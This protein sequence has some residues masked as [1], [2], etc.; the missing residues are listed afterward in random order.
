MKVFSSLTLLFLFAC[1]DGDVEPDTDTDTDTDS[2]APWPKAF[3]E[4]AEA[5]EQQRLELGAPG[6]AV[7]IWQD[8]E[9][10]FSHGFGSGHP[11]EAQTITGDTLF[12]I[13]SV[14][15]MLTSTAALQQVQAG[16]TA[17][18][19]PISTLLPDLTFN[20]GAGR[21]ETLTLHNTMT[22]QGGF[23]DWTP[24]NGSPNDAFLYTFAHTTFAQN[25]FFIAPTEAFYNYSNPN[26]LMAG[27]LAEAADDNRLYPQIMAEDVFEPLGMD[28]TFFKAESVIADGDYA[29]G[30]TIDWTGQTQEVRNAIPGSYDHAAMRPAGFAWSST[31]QLLNFAHFLMHGNPEVLDDTHRA[32]LTEKHVDTLNYPN[33]SHYGYGVFTQA[34][35]NGFGGYYAE[36]IW[37]HGGA[38]YGFSTQLFI[39]PEKDFAIAILANTDGAYFGNGIAK[40]IETLVDDLPAPGPFPPAEIESDFEQYAGRYLDPQNVGELIVS[41]ED[42]QLKVEAPTLTEYG[43][44]I[45]PTLEPI[46]KHNFRMSLDGNPL[47][48]TFIAEAE[49]QPAKWMRNRVFVAERTETLSPAT[50]PFD[51]KRFQRQLRTPVAPQALPWTNVP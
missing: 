9:V 27:L 15:K 4:I 50:I 41:V 31:N 2:D 42:G 34:G 23:Y 35:F 7:S 19:E 18:D 12:R 21:T 22:H 26:Y 49:G 51:A 40:A 36:P 47:A 30:R 48:I 8:G 6:V 10:V 24:V 37:Q 28:R 1:N 25:I 5:F 45:G 17:L 14:T 20:R 32:L 29:T 46:S 33:W 38:I 44:T 39:L 43:Y 3:D 11:D 13:G 16:R